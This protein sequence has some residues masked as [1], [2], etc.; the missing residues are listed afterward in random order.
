M[1]NRDHNDG[2]DALTRAMERPLSRS[3]LLR[4]MV[5]AVSAAAL[6]S[7][8]P[9][10]S[11]A[12]VF[13]LN[14]PRP[15]GPAT[16]S[17]SPKEI[18]LFDFLSPAQKEAARRGR[19]P[20]VTAELKQF[21]DAVG[22]DGGV[23]IIDPYEYAFE[24]STEEN[25]P[26]GSFSEVANYTL[27]A[28]GAV[29]HDKRDDYHVDADK[30]DPLLN[31]PPTVPA[32]KHTP[33][34]LEFRGCEGIVIEGLSVTTQRG[35]FVKITD[36]TGATKTYGNANTWGLGTLHFW[37]DGT[38][39]CRKVRVSAN[40]VGGRDAVRIGVE[41]N[42]QE[43]IGPSGSADEDIQVTLYARECF[44]ALRV[45]WSG[46]DIRADVFADHCIR[47]IFINGVNGL[48]LTLITYDQ[49]YSSII[50]SRRTDT[51]NVF[52]R[53]INIGGNE[54]KQFLQ[55]ELWPP[56]PKPT[57]PVPML[58]LQWPEDGTVDP[59]VLKN[60]TIELDANNRGGDLAFRPAIAFY[61]ESESLSCGSNLAKT[62]DGLEVYGI[63]RRDPPQLQPCCVKIL[64]QPEKPFRYCTTFGSVGRPFQAACGDSQRNVYV[65]DLRIDVA[66]VLPLCALVDDELRVERIHGH[67]I[68]LKPADCENDF[69]QC[70]SS[71][72]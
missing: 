17:K 60:I 15:N 47:P 1:N 67:L 36:P 58:L 40:V 59:R 20:D 66:T 25:N 38:R 7:A 3:E 28:T 6:S 52:L 22:P 32:Y 55:Y 24:I 46:V 41:D 61:I 21:F 42:P 54:R 56:R 53:Y 33:T 18:R 2:L 43:P 29:L 8:G 30:D 34:F 48:H 16:S 70:V 57:E 65:H 10:Q 35:D 49:Q 4:L 27:N 63:D 62:L 44:R 69:A 72:L 64:G 51:E 26:L 13:L 50:E 37:H 39:P 12:D 5:G 45:Q 71:R 23:Y 31:P 68:V 11:R 14:G 19:I 9:A